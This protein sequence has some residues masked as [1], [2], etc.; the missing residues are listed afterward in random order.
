VATITPIAATGYNQNMIVS[1][2]NGSANITATMDGGTAKTGDTFF[3][4]GI[5]TAGGT[6]TPPPPVSGVPKA[7]V[8]FGSGT[9]AN[10]TFVFQP[11]GAGQNDAV[12]LDAANTAGTLNLA[13]PARY[14]LLSVLVSAGNGGAPINYTIRYAGGATQTGSIPGPDWFNNTPIAFDSNGRV[15]VALDDYNN[16]NNGNPRM[17]Q[18]DIT[19]TNTTANVLG[20]D[21]TYGG[22]GGTDREAVFGISGQAVPE[23]SSL[24][25]LSIGAAGLVIRR[26]RRAK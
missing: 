2:T 16:I 20:I 13:A 9:D 12:M 23:P 19:L 15:D 3:E 11:N 5:T 8:V 22:T 21:F 7:G 17:Y 14:T 24:A 26:R 4:Q 1:A 10:H 25:F 18:D 6:A